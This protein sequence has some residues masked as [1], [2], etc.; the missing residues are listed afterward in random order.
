MARSHARVHESLGGSD[1]LA[2]ACSFSMLVFFLCCLVMKV[3]SMSEL[4]AVQRVMS[5]EQKVMYNVPSIALS[6]ILLISVV[7]SLVLSSMVLLVQ[8]RAEQEKMALEERTSKARR[9]RHRQSNKEA[10]VPKIPNN[11]FHTFLSRVDS[12]ALTH[13]HPLGSTPVIA[14][15]MTQTFGEPDKTRVFTLGLKH[16][17]C[18]SVLTLSPIEPH[19]IQCA[20]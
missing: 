4:E 18:R 2:S 6:V 11:S 5:R 17:T 1:F 14:L 16:G 10:E 19:C 15:R 7:A 8:L 9:L 12:V 3:A 13:G 20:L